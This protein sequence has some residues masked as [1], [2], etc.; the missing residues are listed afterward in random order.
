[1]VENCPGEFVLHA[2]L[3][4]AGYWPHH[5]NFCR[6]HIVNNILACP[7]MIMSLSFCLLQPPYV[8]IFSLSIFISCVAVPFLIGVALSRLLKSRSRS[9]L[10]V[11][12]SR[13]TNLWDARCLVVFRLQGWITLT[14]YLV[15]WS[16]LLHGM[17]QSWGAE[18][19][20]PLSSYGIP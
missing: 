20:M 16:I 15:M 4:Q 11:L 3:C 2:R 13:A 6:Y 18:M 10:V 19:A 14:L 1:M 5:V 12:V 9:P 17:L 8:L 7:T